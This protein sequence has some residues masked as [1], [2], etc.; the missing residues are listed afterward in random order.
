MSSDEANKR[1]RIPT[2]IPDTV[3]SKDGGNPNEESNK[4]RR[5]S[6]DALAS[7]AAS[8][9]VVTL[10]VTEKAT[11]ADAASVPTEELDTPVTTETANTANTASTASTATEHEEAI[12]SIGKMIQDL[13]HSDNDNVNAALDT[14]YLGL[15]KD[16]KKCESLVIAG[17]CHA[18]VQLM[19]KCLDETFARVQACGQVTELNELVELTTLR[20]TLNV[21]TNLTFQHVESRVGI[22]A[23]GGV[24]ALVKIMR[25]FPKC[26]ALQLHACSCLLNLASCSIGMTNAVES[27]GIEAVLAAINNHLGS[28]ILCRKACVVLCNM[29]FVN[30]ENTKILISMG[31]GAT[32]DKAKRKWSDDGSIQTQVRKLASFFAV[33]WKARADKK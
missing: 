1:K 15:D 17:S 10:V 22:S 31:G 12:Q 20:K 25:T 23:T 16:K 24:E 29:M 7:T 14:L 28:E 18:L 5:V 19:K 32:V 8:V 4:A 33:E 6:T 9:Q 3:S 27:G 21:I 11:T 30:K 26:E 13:F 2:T